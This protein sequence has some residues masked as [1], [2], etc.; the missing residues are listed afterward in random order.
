[1]ASEMSELLTPKPPCASSLGTEPL[2]GVHSLLGTDSLSRSEYRPPTVP[3]GGRVRCPLSVGCVRHRAQREYPFGDRSS[4]GTQLE[5]DTRRSGLDARL[6]KHCHGSAREVC[7][8]AQVNKQ[9]GPVSL[10]VVVDGLPEER[11]LGFIQV[12]DH[13]EHAGRLTDA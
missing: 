12:S 4:G 10:A 13:R 9:V 11:D 8:P 2:P 6:R 3:G 1:M 5:E 7:D